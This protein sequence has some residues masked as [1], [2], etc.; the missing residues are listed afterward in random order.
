[1]R[2]SL[3]IGGYFVVFAA[4]IGVATLLPRLVGPSFD[5][6]WRQL[7]RPTEGQGIYYSDEVF[8][9]SDLPSPVISK[10]V[11]EAKFIDGNSAQAVGTELG[12]KVIVDV[13]PVDLSKI[14]KKYLKEK[15]VN[16]GGTTIT[17]LPIE[18]VFHDVRF[19]FTLKD[20]DGFKLLEAQSE[21]HTLESGKTNTLQGIAMK[22][23]PIPIAARTAQ[24]LFHMRVEK[25]ITCDGE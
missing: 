4:G 11:G 8:L 9:K 3:T 21:P 17:Q 5:T 2:K 13:G 24:V 14:P 15:P 18:Q 10:L 16:V 19:E 20:K 6:Q 25:C 1:M 23:V 22:P 7:V 12:Y